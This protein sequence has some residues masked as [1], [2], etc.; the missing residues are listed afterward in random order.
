MHLYRCI[1]SVNG[2]RT[3][4]TVKAQSSIEAKKIIEASFPGARIVWWSCNKV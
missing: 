3:E 1:F 2:T 4:Q